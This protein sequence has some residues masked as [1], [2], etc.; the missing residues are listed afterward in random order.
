MF[1]SNSYRHSFLIG[2]L[3]RCGYFLGG[4][5]W[6]AAPLVLY[7]FRDYWWLI[8]FTIVLVPGLLGLYIGILAIV[9]HSF[10]FLS[11]A[12]F[13]LSF[14]CFWVFF[15]FLR[16]ELFTGFPWLAA[17][18]SLV[19]WPTLIQS[20]SLFG[21]FWLSFLVIS[22]SS[23]LFVLFSN[24]V[25]PFTKTWICFAV[26][27]FCAANFIYGNARL[28]FN[29]TV[30]SKDMVK[31]IQPNI[32][33]LITRTT[34][35]A[36]AERIIKL[37][38]LVDESDHL[39]Y[40]LLPESALNFFGSEKTFSK[41]LQNIPEKGYLLAGGDRRE[42]YGTM[43]RT[44]ISALVFNREGLL[45]DKYDKTHLVPFGEYIPLKT[46]APTRLHPIVSTFLNDF[47]DFSRG[48]G[49][50][51]INVANKFS[52]SPLICYESLFPDNII[53]LHNRPDLLINFTTD[54]WYGNTSGPYQHFDMSVLRGVEYGMPLIRV[55]TTGI[56]GITDQYGRILAKL[57]RGKQ[58]VLYKNIPIRSGG[59]T[60]YSICGNILILSFLICIL[61]SI[62]YARNNK[63]LQ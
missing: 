16:T 50:K 1:R 23:G 48:T 33:G 8:P 30:L 49:P 3:F 20:A 39:L 46:L 11:L 54:M 31:I 17:G 51:T 7:F 37:A 15:E 58:G 59:S 12:G 2:W 38:K 27:G 62:I 19:K 6:I 36:D 26:A 4:V 41:L 21:I 52:F 47:L 25:R 9:T 44:W 57:D 40:V 18:Y 29:K 32:D 24:G 61:G 55:A 42:G 13:S 35:D 53:D 45:L 34:M 43:I 10:K 60:L 22:I 5:Y 28:R 14:S 56:S 63:L